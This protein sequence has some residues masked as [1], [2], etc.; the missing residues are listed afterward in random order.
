MAVTNAA[1]E[2]KKERRQKVVI[3]LLFAVCLSGF[4][5][6]GYDYFQIVNRSTL[7]ENFA[8]VDQTVA[9]WQS[10]GLVEKFD[11]STAKLV[12]DGQRWKSMSKVEKIGVVTQLARYC[13]GEKKRETWTLKVVDNATS[14][15][16]GEIGDRG[17]MVQ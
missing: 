17:L 8:G 4:S 15:V 6:L 3:I 2:E 13:A 12:V 14:S 11:V 10:T 7:P 9:S 1:D 16:V 5:Y